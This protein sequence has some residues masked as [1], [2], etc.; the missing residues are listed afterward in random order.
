MD[1]VVAHIEAQDLG[2]GEM[3]SMLRGVAQ[4]KM[5]KDLRDTSMATWFSKSAIALLFPVTSDSDGHW[6]GMWVDVKRKLVI[7]FD[8]YGFGPDIEDRYSSDPIV[9]EK[10]LQ[11][12][13]ATCQSKGFQIVISPLQLQTMSG[14]VNTCGRH[15]ICR[16]RLRYLDD[17]Q[18]S[19]L[20]SDQ[21][22]TPDEIVTYLTFLALNEDQKDKAEMLEIV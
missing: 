13:Y 8:P 7:H 12:F 4:I 22:L 15:V 21:K 11:Q 17:R 16:L 18:Y 10:L 9:Q 6:I 2:G 19:S 20:I 1:K 14:K 5:Y 3:T